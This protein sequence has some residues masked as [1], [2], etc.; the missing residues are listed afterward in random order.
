M[1]NQISS[2]LRFGV[3]ALTLGAL[4]FCSGC[5]TA[6]KPVAAGKVFHVGL[7]WLKEPGNAAHRQQIVAAAHAFAR[8]IPE[9]QFLSVGQ[10]PPSPSPY[11]DASFDV[12]VVMQF[13]DK[14]A[15]ERYNK[16]PVHQ[17]A[18]QEAFLPLSKKILFY[19][20]I[21]E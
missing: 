9:V 16:H 12:C 7:V 19:D 14:A 21:S 3:L 11:V 15:M 2:L 10:S 5:A 4:G 20:F 13:A 17:K 6:P 18:A 8:E 1:K